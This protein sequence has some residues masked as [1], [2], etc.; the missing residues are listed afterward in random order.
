MSERRTDQETSSVCWLTPH[1]HETARVGPGLH[2]TATPILTSAF[3][4][5]SHLLG[6]KEN[7]YARAHRS[8]GTSSCLGDQP[9]ESSKVLEEETV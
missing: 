3:S 6:D 9:R 2:C 8:W 4:T 7:T 1:T 5:R